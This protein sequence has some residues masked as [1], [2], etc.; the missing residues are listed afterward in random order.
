MATPT[1]NLGLTTLEEGQDGAELDHNKALQQLDALV[2]M[3]FEDRDLTAPPGGESN[4]DTYLVKATATG[5]WATH[6]GEIAY[7]YD[8][9]I[10]TD[11]QEGMSARVKDEDVQIYFDGVTW[12][13]TAEQ[14]T[15]GGDEEMTLTGLAGRTFSITCSALLGGPVTSG[16]CT[17]DG[18][19]STVYKFSLPVAC[20]LAN[21]SVLV[22]HLNSSDP[23]DWSLLLRDGTPTTLETMVF[24]LNA[25]NWPVS[26]ITTGTGSASIA[27]TDELQLSL[28][29][30]SCSTIVVRAHL[31]FETT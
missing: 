18:Q 24:E 16:N 7:Y 17:V 20:D 13:T 29:G 2:H 31:I 11:P 22:Y 1:E 26:Q 28:T 9:W 19:D 3:A 15:T 30:P 14:L 5:D 6:D 21:W 23:G 25:S 12:N 4:G 27:T 10:F 8:G